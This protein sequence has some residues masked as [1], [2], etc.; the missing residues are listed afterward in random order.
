MVKLTAIILA[1]TLNAGQA[2]MPEWFWYSEHVA[3]SGAVP[4]AIH[5]CLRAMKVSKP[6]AL[7]VGLGVT[8]AGCAVKELALDS[9]VDP[10]D[11][12]CNVVGLTF[13]AIMLAKFGH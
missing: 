2:S 3:I 13:A 9:R 7:G 8:A 4:F 5:D 11:V 6:V 1:I 10:A 12:L